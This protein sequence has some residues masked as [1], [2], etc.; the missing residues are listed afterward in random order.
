MNCRFWSIKI[1]DNNA[2]CHRKAPLPFI[3]D[4]EEKALDT[5]EVKTRWPITNMYQYCGEFEEKKK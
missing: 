3:G 2:E 1:N 4:P 5:L